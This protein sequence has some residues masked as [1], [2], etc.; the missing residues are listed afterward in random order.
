[1][2]FSFDTPLFL[3]APGLQSVMG[4]TQV[5]NTQ[6]R[7]LTELFYA[8]PIYQLVCQWHSNLTVLRAE[9]RYLDKDLPSLAVTAKNPWYR[10]FVILNQV[11]RKDSRKEQRKAFPS[12]NR[13]RSLSVYGL[14]ALTYTQAFGTLYGGHTYPVGIG[15]MA[16]PFSRF[17]DSAGAIKYQFSFD[18]IYSTAKLMQGLGSVYHRNSTL[19][20]FGDHTLTFLDVSHDVV[21]YRLDNIIYQSYP[22]SKSM[23]LASATI[24]YHRL[25]TVAPF[26]VKVTIDGLKNLVY[27]ND[28]AILGTPWISTASS[29][30]LI[31]DK[32]AA[33]SPDIARLKYRVRSCLG[34][35]ASDFRPAYYHTQAEAFAK[36][37]LDM[38]SN[39]ENFVESPELVFLLESVLYA[40]QVPWLK[41]AY[42][43]SGYIGRIALLV[44]LISGG[45]LLWNYALQPSYKA[46]VA[47][48][49][50]TLTPILGEASMNFEGSDVNTLPESLRMLIT[51]NLG[52]FA[53]SSSD[54]RRFELSFRSEVRTT[55]DYQTLTSM[56]MEQ[57]PLLKSHIVPS[58]SQFWASVTGSFLVDQWV[59]ISRYLE[60]HEAYILSPTVPFR[61]GHT[62]SIKLM[63]GQGFTLKA[64][65]RSSESNF[66]TDPPGDTWL[67]A[68]GASWLNLPL[69]FSVLL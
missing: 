67:L 33:N 42:Q 28:P 32:L 62:A 4:Q 14:S 40:E 24:A 59:P 44:K 63:M 9:V 39:F 30:Y 21:S 18:D 3:G 13:R 55:L 5:V 26:G 37:M 47:L 7:L 17:R 58:P 15:T 45:L 53:V 36:V 54:I 6:S 10:G 8:D 68:P 61:I 22:S 16:V 12:W 48:A 38:S 51:R 20:R 46:V 60:A 65:L 34:W 35:N 2:G 27:D 66:L 29:T 57:Q 43:A 1:V 41:K 50:Q 52:D 56:L 31:R 69:A 23:R 25:D 64:F 19:G 11:L 49:K